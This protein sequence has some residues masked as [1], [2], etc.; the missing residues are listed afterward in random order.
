MAL[1]NTESFRIYTPSADGSSEI[2]I[3]DSVHLPEWHVIEQARFETCTTIQKVVCNLS[4]TAI[5][6]LDSQCELRT[7]KPSRRY[8]HRSSMFCL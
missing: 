4:L 5:A 2:K 1:D 3:Y 8:L 6:L 7:L